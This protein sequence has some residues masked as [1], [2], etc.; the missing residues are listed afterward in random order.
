[1]SNWVVGLVVVISLQVAVAEA[2]PLDVGVATQ[3]EV[4]Q[5]RHFDGV[6]EAVNRSTVSAQVAGRIEAV[7]FDV[8]DYV[9]KGDLLVEIRSASQRAALKSARAKLNEAQ[10]RLDEAESEYRR[11]EEIYRQKLVAKMKLD[12]ASATLK[13]ARARLDSAKAGVAEALELVAHTSVRAPYSGIVTKRDAEV[14]EMASVGRALMSGLSL[15]SLRIS[16]ELP[17]REV[18]SIRRHD[19]ARVILPSGGSLAVAGLLLFPVADPESHAFRVRLQL[20]QGD[21]GLLPGMFA[22]VAFVTG[23]AMK[24][25]V[26]VQSVVYR[27]EVTGIYV[28]SEA[29]EVS[30]R[31]LRLGRHFGEG[32]IEVLAGL[33]A[34][35]QVALNPI[36]AGMSLKQGQGR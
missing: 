10:A 2:A 20:P 29:G 27:G 30:F 16:V 35:E 7:H 31:Q 21:H 15:E 34:G 18:A 32:E 9:K 13:S 24:L 28:V 23:S 11:I 3:R 5:L 22:K 26:P 12:Q 17:Q 19:H 8:D 6:V 33:E 36:K 25:L 4:A 14:G 1:M